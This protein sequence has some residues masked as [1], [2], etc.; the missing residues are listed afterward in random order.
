MNTQF[1]TGISLRD[2]TGIT[3][4]VTKCNP[5]MIKILIVICCFAISACSKTKE[6][7]NEPE[8][9]DVLKDKFLIGTALNIDQF[10]GRDESFAFRPQLSVEANCTNDY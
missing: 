1:F 6:A 9:K 7:S 2:K 8:L 4:S 10:N 5:W 3:A